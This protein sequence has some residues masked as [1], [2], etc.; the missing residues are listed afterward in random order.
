ML[1]SAPGEKSLSRPA[2][3]IPLLS[4]IISDLVHV[5]ADLHYLHFFT[6]QGRA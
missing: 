6:P 3:A 5:S 4:A 1:I 2:A